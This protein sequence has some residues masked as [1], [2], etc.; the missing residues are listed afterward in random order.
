MTINFTPGTRITSD[1]LNDVDEKIYQGT[2][3]TGSTTRRTLETRAAD[4]V[5]VKDYGAV[6]DGV[7]DDTAAIQAAIDSLGSTYGGRVF[8]PTGI[9]LT[10]SVIQITRKNVELAGV[11]DGSVI[12]NASHTG[13][14]IIAGD[15]YSPG[16]GDTDF[17]ARNLNLTGNG[18]ARDGISLDAFRNAK[19]YNINVASVTRDGFRFGTA[20]GSY[21]AIAEDCYVSAA[22]NAAFHISAP[23]VKLTRCVN[24]GGL[25]SVLIDGDGDYS[26]HSQCHYE[27]ATTGAIYINGTNRGGN[28]V[29][30][31]FIFPY[32]K[33]AHGIFIS[34]NATHTKN[35]IVGNVLLGTGADGTGAGVGIYVAG[36]NGD[37]NVIVA[38][39]IADYEYGLS[40]TG[41]SNAVSANTIDVQRDGILVDGDNNTFSDLKITAAGTN[42]INVFSGTGNVAV[43]CK[44]TKAFTGITTIDDK[45]G[46]WT[47]SVGGDATYTA[48]S[49][50]YTKLGRQVTI[51]GSMTINVLGTG[52]TSVITGLPY[53]AVTGRTYA[54]AVSYFASLAANVVFIAAEVSDGTVGFSTMAAAGATATG[55]AACIG[56]ATRL[57]FTVTYETAAS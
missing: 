16:A 33:N 57:D 11:P 1:W 2:V 56:N 53:A 30:G 9:Y 21:T 54:G 39:D 6:G 25:Y 28:K 55:G 12:I 42:A 37:H 3:A 38:N 35:Q 46:T 15:T 49:G 41:D 48:Q 40:I 31:N 22:T 7:T 50:T 14:I 13:D 17:T 44:S 24:D 20:T 51:R 26:F 34:S 23:H 5:N 43:A 29:I 32:G 36:T 10:S 52:S 47:P 27:G 19:L 45:I 8:L 4:V 18:T